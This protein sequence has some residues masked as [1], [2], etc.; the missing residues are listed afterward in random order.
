MYT[1]RRS[2]M[3]EGTE[4]KAGTKISYDLDK[5]EGNDYCRIVRDY[6]ME[7]D[8]PSISIVPAIDPNI[9]SALFAFAAS[10]PVEFVRSMK[11]PDF[12]EVTAGVQVFLTVSDSEE[13]GIQSEP[14]DE[15][16]SKQEDSSDVAQSG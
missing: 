9:Q 13:S 6:T 3:F 2:F 14:S 15:P 11:L 1:I 12:L 8:N 10:K 16:Q 7:G 4:Y 5:L